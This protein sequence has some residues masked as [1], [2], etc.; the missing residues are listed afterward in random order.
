MDKTEAFWRIITCMLIIT[1]FMVFGI[2]VHLCLDLLNI[3]FVQL[4]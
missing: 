4:P 2:A 3:H 1:L